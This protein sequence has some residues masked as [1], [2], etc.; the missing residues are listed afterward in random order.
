MKKLYILAA[1]LVAATA[2]AHDEGHGPKLGDGP[3][4]YP[5]V[6]ASEA[7]L[8]SKAG[9]VY[10][11]KLDR[12]EDGTM[13]FVVLK[14]KPANEEEKKP[15]TLEKFSATAKAALEF[16]KNKKWNKTPFELKKEGNAFTGKAPKAG[17]K[18]FNIDVIFSDGT[19]EL[20]VAF[21]NLD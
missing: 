11:A 16:K 5:V 18:P 21:D 13:S 7:K 14:A 20:L 19:E 17:K 9:L 8:G 15:M 3:D 12:K 1:M 4:I 10:R 2:S 6:K